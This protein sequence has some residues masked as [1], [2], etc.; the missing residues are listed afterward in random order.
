MAR[1]F[2]PNLRDILTDG[3]I[4]AIVAKQR[5]R[6]ADGPG[7]PIFPPTYLGSD[8]RPTYCI[9]L[10]DDG[11]NVCVV[12]SVQSQANRI[13]AAFMD[14]PYRSLVRRVQVTAQL[15]NA[16]TRTL[17]MLQLGHRLAD[18]AV[19]F[20]T[21]AEQAKAA[22][23]SFG[24]GPDE[25]ARLSPMSLLF[26]MWES[27]GEKRQTRI[28]R[29]LSSTITARN[30]RVL[31]RMATF[32]GSFWSK[33]LGLEGKRSSEGLDPVPTGEALGGIMAEGEI[34]RSATLNLVALRQNCKITTAV[35]V[36]P[37]AWYMFAL[38][39]V[40][41]TVPS[42]SYLRQG[43]LLV[44]DGDIEIRVVARSGKDENLTLD[45]QNILGIARDAA[46]DFGV[47]TLEPIEAVFQ[48]DRLEPSPHR[49][50]QTTSRRQ[51]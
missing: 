42:E 37:A 22:M 12:D 34:L 25:I 24:D 4:V 13:E 41:I 5:L 7:T 40:A 19:T 26:G 31:R 33:D 8:D 9:S 18:A 20:S 29:A 49:Q 30:V 11:G 39:L 10:L 15:P 46:R 1:T 16:E 35:P 36:S 43:C 44:G 21:L 38:A 48:T 32:A 51:G 27:R 23:H 47:S 50:G 14:E 28:P 45:H 2:H 6:A 17:D 3:N